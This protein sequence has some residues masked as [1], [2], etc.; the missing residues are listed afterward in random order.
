MPVSSSNPAFRSARRISR[1]QILPP[2]ETPRIGEYLSTLGACVRGG[3]HGKYET[4]TESR[5][6][7]FAVVS[8]RAIVFLRLLWP[9]AKHQAVLKMLEMYAPYPGNF[10]NHRPSFFHS[11]SPGS[12]AAGGSH[13]HHHSLRGQSGRASH[14]GGRRRARKSHQKPGC[15]LSCSRRSQHNPLGWKLTRRGSPF[16][17]VSCSWALP[18]AHR[19]A[20]P[21]L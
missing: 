2:T 17:P 8:H 19:S 21:V 9:M 15:R 1:V 3:W 14:P 6:A 11:C 13:C 16:G 7:G 18:P 4:E 20:S 12:E 10:C 5:D